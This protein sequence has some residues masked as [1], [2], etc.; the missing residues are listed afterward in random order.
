MAGIII[1]L[2]SNNKTDYDKVHKIEKRWAKL[3]RNRRVSRSL[4]KR[5]RP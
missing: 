4:I 2:I 3:V 5:L 1:A